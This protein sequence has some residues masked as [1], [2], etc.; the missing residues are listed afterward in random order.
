[1]IGKAFHIG[2]GISAMVLRCKRSLI[3]DSERNKEKTGV[4]ETERMIKLKGYEGNIS[5]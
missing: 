2:G 4:T 1:M 3:I 5:Y